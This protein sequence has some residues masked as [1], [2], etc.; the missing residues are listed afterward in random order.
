MVIGAEPKIGIDG[1]NPEQFEFD[2]TVSDLEE[3]ES[4]P[5]DGLETGTINQPKILNWP[6]VGINGI[7]MAKVFL[8]GDLTWHGESN[9]RGEVG[10]IVKLYVTDA[11][12]DEIGMNLRDG[13]GVVRH[14]TDSGREMVCSPAAATLLSRG[15]EQG[16]VTKTEKAE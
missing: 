15:R 7:K 1:E 6:D 10:D 11:E 14:I 4:D 5:L 16:R 8:Y 2:A 12:K 13:F 3:P 9:L